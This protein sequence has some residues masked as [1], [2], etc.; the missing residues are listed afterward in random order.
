MSKAKLLTAGDS[1]RVPVDPITLEV[2]RHGIIS[3][4]SNIAPKL[5][6]QLHEAWWQRDLNT[7]AAI[8]DRLMPLSTALFAETSPGPVKYGAGLLGLCS[9]EVRL[10]L[11]EV[12][13]PVDQQVP[14]PGHRC[15]RTR[16]RAERL[17]QQRR[18]PNSRFAAEQAHRPPVPH[19]R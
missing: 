10:P 6:A 12:G 7:F 18:F 19:P 9:P 13:V 16:Q 4:C 15:Q 17:K 8:R 11:V 3:V 14:E 5:N 2:I 1:F